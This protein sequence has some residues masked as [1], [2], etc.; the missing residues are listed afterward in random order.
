VVHEIENMVPG[1]PRSL[2]TSVDFPDPDG[3]DTMTIL[4]EGADMLFDVLYLFAKLFDL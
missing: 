4:G 3:P 2:S 1:N